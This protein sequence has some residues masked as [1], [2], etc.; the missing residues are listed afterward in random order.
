MLQPAFTVLFF[1][2]KLRCDSGK[3]DTVHCDYCLIAPRY[4]YTYCILIILVP[5][6]S[7]FSYIFCGSATGH[8]TT[9]SLG[10]YQ[11]TDS[12]ANFR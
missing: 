1:G 12:A 10:S 9:K 8:R 11:V 3:K 6:I 4:K 2:L 5:N 7:R